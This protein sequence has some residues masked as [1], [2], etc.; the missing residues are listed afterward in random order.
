MKCPLFDF[1]DSI[2]A[3]C[4]VSEPDEGCYYY[5]YFHDLI[6]RKEKEKQKSVCNGCP[7]FNRCLSSSDSRKEECLWRPIIEEI[8]KN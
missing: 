4:R 2:T 5:R 6:Q 7:A 3:T 1:C 8:N